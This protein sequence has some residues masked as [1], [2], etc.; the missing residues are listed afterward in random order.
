MRV[1]DRITHIYVCGVCGEEYDEETAKQCEKLPVE[2]QILEKGDEVRGRE[3]IGVVLDADLISPLGDYAT[4]FDSIP[5]GKHFY[6]YVI[7]WQN[8]SI[9][10]HLKNDLKYS[11]I[12][13]K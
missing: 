7:K 4:F 12:K 10:R 11:G 8:G 9:S 3:S 1:E 5:R 2:K 13:K 6:V